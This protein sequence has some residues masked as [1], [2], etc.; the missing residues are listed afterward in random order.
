M[1]EASL[2]SAVQGKLTVEAAEKELAEVT[3]RRSELDGVVRNM[4]EPPESIVETNMSGISILRGEGLVDVLELSSEF[5]H[6]VT[7]YQITHKGMRLA[8]SLRVASTTAVDGLIHAPGS[9][10]RLRVV[11]DG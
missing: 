1:L 5:G 10:E 6:R 8:R 7:C 11:W 2:Q 3:R 4:K 9:V